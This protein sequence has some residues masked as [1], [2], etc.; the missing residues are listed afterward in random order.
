MLTPFLF[1]FIN[2]LRRFE[3]WTPWTGGQNW[4]IVRS[5]GLIDWSVPCLVLSHGSCTWAWALSTAAFKLL[6]SEWRWSGMVL[7]STPVR[8]IS[9]FLSLIFSNKFLIQ[10][11]S[12]EYDIARAVIFEYF[13]R[14]PSR[15]RL[16]LVHQVIEE[17]GRG[18]TSSFLFFSSTCVGLIYLYACT[19]KKNHI[20]SQYLWISACPWLDC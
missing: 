15:S 17:R 4:N 13:I 10:Q 19:C 14:S 12:Q 8:M 9:F 18:I 20:I 11:D 6:T 1:F 16:H 5:T 3:M 7:S 2:Q